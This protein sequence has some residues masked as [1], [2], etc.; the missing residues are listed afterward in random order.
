MA[1]GTAGL[2]VTVARVDTFAYRSLRYDLATAPDMVADTGETFVPAE[3][4]ITDGRPGPPGR[5]SRGVEIEMIGPHPSTE[6]LHG[7]VFRNWSS[8]GSGNHAVST[9]P[10]WVRAL[11][12][13]LQ[14]T[15]AG[16]GDRAGPVLIT[17]GH[18]G[19]ITETEWRIE[20]TGAD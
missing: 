17:G 12:G 11:A 13:L 5:P 9:A 2:Q 7:R 14:G 20:L 18:S 1:I 6:R 19:L 15:C 10:N 3:V 4:R 16:Q 8:G